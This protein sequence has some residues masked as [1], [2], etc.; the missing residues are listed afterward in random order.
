MDRLT[1]GSLYPV[2]RVVKFDKQVFLAKRAWYRTCLDS[3]HSI[4]RYTGADS[5]IQTGQLKVCEYFVLGNDVAARSP[6]VTD[7]WL[8]TVFHTFDS[9][10][11]CCWHRPCIVDLAGTAHAGLEQPCSTGIRPA[12]T[13]LFLLYLIWSP[14][15]LLCW[16]DMF[17][18]ISRSSTLWL[19]SIVS[20]PSILAPIKKTYLTDHCCHCF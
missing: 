14:A 10:C 18:L 9:L 12:H 15:C 6:R 2:R 20:I 5:A 7:Q 1:A 11:H 8:A 17:F 13:S 16:C 4:R 19:L 3:E